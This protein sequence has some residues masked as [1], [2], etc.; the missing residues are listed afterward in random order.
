MLAKATELAKLLGVTRA[1][2]YQWAEEP[3]F[4]PGIKAGR[5]LVWDVDAVKA[6]RAA[7]PERGGPRPGV[8]VGKL[9]KPR[10]PKDN[11]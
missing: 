5:G 7:R 9:K 8:W 10:K 4:P 2:V 3:D 6:W 1:R 11:P